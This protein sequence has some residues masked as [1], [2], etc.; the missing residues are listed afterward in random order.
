MTRTSTVRVPR[1]VRWC[2]FPVVLLSSRVTEACPVTTDLIIRVNKRTTT[3]TTTASDQQYVL[4]PTWTRA[5][6]ELVLRR[7]S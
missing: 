3:T 6:M 5:A 4:E 7:W 1:S 2:C